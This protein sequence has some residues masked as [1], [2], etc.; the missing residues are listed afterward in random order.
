M[1]LKKTVLNRYDAFELV[2]SAILAYCNVF[3]SHVFPPALVPT[4]ALSFAPFTP[5]LNRQ[6]EK[7]TVRH[8]WTAI[9]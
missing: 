3:D 7:Q 6:P 4:L 9:N 2:N 8:L 5:S 1:Y